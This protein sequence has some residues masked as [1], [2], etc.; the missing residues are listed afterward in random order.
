M[1]GVL[2]GQPVGESPGYPVIRVE[3]GRS[4]AYLVNPLT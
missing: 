4:L 3:K 2:E 1:R